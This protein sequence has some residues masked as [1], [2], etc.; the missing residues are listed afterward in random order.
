AHRAGGRRDLEHVAVAEV[1]GAEEGRSSVDAGVIAVTVGAQRRQA[2]VRGE[3]SA[4]ETRR[5]LAARSPRAKRAV[6]ELQLAAARRLAQ[7]NG[8]HVDRAGVRRRA[9]ARRADAAL[10]LHRAQA[11]CEIWKVGEVEHLV[12]R[13]V[14]RDAVEGEVDPRLIDPA[15]PDVAVAPVVAGF[16]VGGEG[17]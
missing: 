9:V 15:Q 13:I 12:F 8:F 14:E 10:D 17:R 4:Y 2:A 6:L 7:R 16:G 1:A 3:S 11:V 5:V